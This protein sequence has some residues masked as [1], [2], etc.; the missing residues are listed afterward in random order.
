MLLN[1]GSL[2]QRCVGKEWLRLKLGRDADYISDPLPAI[3]FAIDSGNTAALK[4]LL[5]TPKDHK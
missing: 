3:Y 5:E 1:K 2:A 4:K